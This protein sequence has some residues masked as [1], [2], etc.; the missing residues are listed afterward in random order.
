MIIARHRV[1]LSLGTLVFAAVVSCGSPPA[2]LV[3]AAASA[4]PSDAPPIVTSP[5]EVPV[6]ETPLPSPPAS[7]VCTPIADLPA[8]TVLGGR[9]YGLFPEGV[10]RLDRPNDPV[11]PIGADWPGG[12]GDARR[13]RPVGLTGVWP[14]R[15]AMQVERRQGN[16]PGGD[17]WALVR[18]QWKKLTDPPDVSG[19]LHVAPAGQGRVVAIGIMGPTTRLLVLAGPHR[20]PGSSQAPS[21]GDCTV[22]ARSFVLAV[23]PGGRVAATREK[24]DDGPRGQPP[25]VEVFDDKLRSLS[26]TPIEHAA[27]IPIIAWLDDETVVA[28]FDVGAPDAPGKLVTITRGKLVELPLALGDRV[29]GLSATADGGMFVATAKHLLRIGRGGALEGS[30]LPWASILQL[31]P[32]ERSFVE[33][34]AIGEDG[35]RYLDVIENRGRQVLRCAPA[36]GG[37]TVP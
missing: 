30:P 35:A 9:P 17:A 12:R 1:G 3:P 11:A 6:V 31:D 18:G 27:G 37:T 29:T 19:Y 20:F 24:C 15:L 33:Q 26:R 7:T 4:G 34:I 16:F 21:T 32:I 8:L 10:R 23:S 36:G 2:P 14:D 28:G 5:P 22:R 13:D 25:L